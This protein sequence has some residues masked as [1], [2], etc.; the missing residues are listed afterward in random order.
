MKDRTDTEIADR[1]A[2]H[3]LSA[4]QAFERLA[5]DHAGLSTAEAVARLTRYGPNLLPRAPRRSALLRFLS[6]FNNVL[7]YL[8][9]AAAAITAVIGHAVDAV[10]IVSV[11]VI[12]AVIGFVQEGRAEAALEAIREMLSPQASVLRDGRRLTLG[13]AALVPGDVVLLEPG[14]RVPADLRLLHVKGLEIDEAVL[15]GESLPVAKQVA[16][17]SRGAAIGD[18]SDLAFFGTLVTRGYGSGVVVGTGLRTEIGR[19]GAL[20]ESV[21]AVTTPLLKRIVRFGQGLAFIVLAAAAAIF[22]WGV[23]VN[24]WPASEMF[25][26]AV[27]LAVAAIPEELPAILTIALAFGVERM[28][29]RNAIVRRLPAVE[30]LGSVTVICSDKTGTLTRNEMVVEEVATVDALYRVTGD[31]Y[32][33]EGRVVGDHGAGEPSGEPSGE[34]ALSELARAVALCS[35]ARLRRDHDGAWRVEGDPMEGAL[36]AFAAKAGVD[37]D[38][39]RAGMPRLDVIPFESET[40][41]MATLHREGDRGVIYVKG[42]PERL[43]ALCDRQ[44]D[45]VRDERIDPARWHRRLEQMTAA[46]ERVIAVATRTVPASLVD[47]DF[48]DLEKGLTMLGLIGLADPPRPEA[49]R[50]VAEC[51]AAGIRIKMITGDHPETARSIAGRFGLS[52]DEV[53]TGRDFEVLSPD[54]LAER[55]AEIDVFARTSPEHKLRL[56]EAL[57]G[58]GEIVAMTGDGVNDAPALKRADVGIAMGIKGSEATKEAAQ[59]VL[60]DD[61]FASIAAAVEQGRTVYENI[62]KSIAF[63]LPTNGGEAMIVI[64]AILVGLPLPITPVQILWINMATTVTLALALAFEPAEADTMKRRPRSPRESI[65]GAYLAWRTVYVSVLITV[66]VFALFIRV[67]ASN[68]LDHARS[69]AVNAIVAFEAFYLLNSRFI[70]RPVLSAHGLFGSR[71]VLIAIAAVIVMQLAFTYLPPFQ[72]LFG[73]RPLTLSDWGLV[74]GAAA[75]LFLIVETEKVVSRGLKRPS[76]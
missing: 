8:L 23:L 43:L 13:A 9:I 5:T 61:N 74:L 73:T 57:Q 17:V 26:A 55:A 62:R 72:A 46:G 16:P 11:V 14:D 15:T 10:V 28:A 37:E 39:A 59:I 56:V 27:G 67:D 51:R 54:E 49:I 53:M 3:A 66:A 4:A 50:A 35:D 63:M 40:Q 76:R 45:A 7:V 64:G 36:L 70:R 24:G 75:G 6:Q 2:W 34:P 25:L 18:R 30:T 44:R 38:G 65:I 22:A 33:P 42:A 52:T 1:I 29:R 21:G 68:G 41:L 19:I 69:V 20:I 47:M 71:P 60:A 31:G 12:N 32:A 58:R 48:G